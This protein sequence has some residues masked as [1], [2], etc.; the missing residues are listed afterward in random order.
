MNNLYSQIQESK[1][2]T[3]S[4]LAS[5]FNDNISLKKDDYN[6]MVEY[7]EVMNY[8]FSLLYAT[9]TQDLISIVQ[10]HCVRQTVDTIGIPQF[11]DL[12]VALYKVP[13][14][15]ALQANGVASSSELGKLLTPNESKRRDADSKYGENHKNP[16]ILIGLVENRDKRIVLSDFGRLFLNLNPAQQARVISALWLR[17]ALIRNYFICKEEETAKSGL[18]DDM[19]QLSESTYKRRLPNVNKIIE[20]VKQG[21]FFESQEDTSNSVSTISLPERKIEKAHELHMTAMRAKPFLLLAGISGTGKS[22]IV[23]QLAFKSCPN[24]D[25]LRKDPTS[26]GNYCLIEVKPNWHDSTELLGYES[27]IKN[28]YVVTPFIKFL[29]KA[30]LYPDAPFFVCLDEMNLAPVEQY[31][32]EFLSVLESRRKYQGHITSEALIPA[33]VFAS[34]NLISEIFDFEPIQD[35]SNAIGTYESQCEY[36]QEFQVYEILKREGL[37]IPENVIVIGTVN[38]DETTH[39]F[40]RKVIDR[41]MTIEMNIEDGSSPFEAFFD[42]NSPLEYESNPIEKGFFVPKYVAASE[43]LETMP[44]DLNEYLRSEIPSILSKLNEALSGTPFKVA[45]RVQNELVLYYNSLS[46]YNSDLEDEELLVRAVDD[47]MMMKILPRIEGD[48]D[49]LSK[50]LEKLADFVAR[51]CKYDGSKSEGK[52]QEMQHRLEQGHFTSFWP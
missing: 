52:I 51:H 1:N 15:L 31:F 38:M 50:P 13:K 21:Y 49:L 35:N 24:N 27:Q 40:S 20:I 9:S 37:R 7:E 33:S 22:R 36:G 12:S 34:Q 26:P 6:S 10:T 4:I 48:E 25:S 8:I 23:K 41:A 42:T 18:E 16:A 19:K 43:A 2:I 11:S 14:V 44:E 32:A 45:Y 17:V 30:M 46:E 39:Q 28:G 47:I 29:A 5:F 3:H